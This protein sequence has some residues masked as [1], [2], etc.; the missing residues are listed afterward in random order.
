LKIKSKILFIALFFLISIS[1]FAQVVE[2]FPKPDFESGY[3]RPDIHLTDAR[4]QVLE[5]V[6]V[7]V[8]FLFLSLASYFGIKQRSRRNIFILVILSL[9]YFGFF[10]EGCKR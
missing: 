5:Y 2:R 4:S 1:S 3:E 8:L 6:D 7:L 10:R 9:G